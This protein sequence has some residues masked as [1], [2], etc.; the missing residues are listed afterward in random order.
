MRARDRILLLIGA[1]LLGTN[2]I[3]QM[4]GLYGVSYQT[5]GQ[6]TNVL[7]DYAYTVVRILQ[8]QAGA[9]MVVL[10]WRDSRS[11]QHAFPLEFGRPPSK[12]TNRFWAEIVASEICCFRLRMFIR[13]FQPVS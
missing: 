6:Y 10:G 5:F 3:F 2:L 4:F 12:S 9:F 1:I 11:N 8:T 13:L 7:T